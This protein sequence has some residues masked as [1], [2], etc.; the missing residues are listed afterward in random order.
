MNPVSAPAMVLT[1][2]TRVRSEQKDEAAPRHRAAPPGLPVPRVHLHASDVKTRVP[3][4]RPNGLGFT[5]RAPHE[6]T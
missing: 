5:V 4:S 6:Q 1:K 3:H 2:L